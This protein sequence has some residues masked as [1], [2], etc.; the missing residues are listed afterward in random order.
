VRKG[1]QNGVTKV[2]VGVSR[3]MEEAKISNPAGNFS[4]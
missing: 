4:G 1:I 2:L 3:R